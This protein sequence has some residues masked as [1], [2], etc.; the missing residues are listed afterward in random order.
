[1]CFGESVVL[2]VDADV[3]VVPHAPIVSPCAACAGHALTLTVIVTDGF[4]AEC[5]RWQIVTFPVVLGVFD[6]VTV[7]LVVDVAVDV[8]TVVDVVPVVLDPLEAST[9]SGL[10]PLASAAATKPS[11]PTPPATAANAMI[12]RIESPLPSAVYEAQN[13]RLWPLR[14]ENS[15]A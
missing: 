9:A 7:V 10:L 12:R 5:V 3:V 4:V 2:V 14:H 8:E 1:M 13:Q 6:V 11:K 15:S